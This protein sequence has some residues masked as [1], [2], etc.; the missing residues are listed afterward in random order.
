VGDEK[1]IRTMPG[2]GSPRPSRV[3]PPPAEFAVV[4]QPAVPKGVVVETVAAA[5]PAPTVFKTIGYV[6]KAGGQ[7]EAVILQDNEVQV[8]HL[9]DLIAGR[10]RVRKLLPEEVDAIDE[11]QAQTPMAKPNGTQS[12]ELTASVGPQPPAPPVAEAA[13]QP[14]ASAGEARSDSPLGMQ[15]AQP[16]GGPLGFV[17]KADGKVEAVVADG[18]TVRLV[19]QTET[20]AQAASPQPPAQVLTTVAAMDA[21]NN[22]AT[23]SD[24]N[25]ARRSS[26]PAQ[27]SDILSASFRVPTSA[28]KSAEISAP[29]LVAMGS[30]RVP[31]GR[32]A[33]GDLLVPS[34]VADSTK[35]S[36]DEFSKLGV[37]MKPLGFVVTGDGELAA[38]LS[39]NDEISIVRQGD[40]FAGR[41]RALSVSADAVEAVE[42]P[43]RQPVASP[44][45]EPRASPDLLT[46]TA[47]HGPPLYSLDDCS[48]CQFGGVGEVSAKL[49]EDPPTPAES[50]PP[51]SRTAEVTLATTAKTAR[52]KKI[53]REDATSPDPATFIFQTLG[54]AQTQDGDIQAIVAEG[55][56]V[57]LVKQ[58]E[59][60]ADQYRATSVDPILVLAVKVLPGQDVEASPS[61]RTES[62]GLAASGIRAESG[63]K[64]ASKKL[65]GYLPFP[66][67]GLA[68]GQ[69]F[70]EL[71]ASGSY[72]SSGL[73]VNLLNSSLTGLDFQAHSFQAS[74]PIVGY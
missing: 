9:G 71:G 49:P 23:G 4:A 48:Q 42:E 10:Y 25:R 11:T 30:T 69:A 6:E 60:F 74:N 52:Q 17:Q 22:S 26:A 41:Y 63:G 18:D 7:V 21:S 66:P 73:A 34:G 43:P 39:L 56:D 70:H 67:L 13:A 15:G 20:L 46:A 51:R 2:Q 50:P 61:S 3:K 62:A 27:S 47:Q 8:V 68:S 14:D 65:Y 29:S 31:Q 55:S 35:K 59:T 54:Y 72:E 57:Y 40:R 32:V 45:A 19:P 37:E 36:I 53:L 58:G 44:L 1:H 33:S 5:P 28:P 38:I 16:S 24:S 64:L 12:N